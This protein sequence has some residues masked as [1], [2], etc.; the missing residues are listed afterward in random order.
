M[1]PFRSLDVSLTHHKT[2][3]LSLC[4]NLVPGFS[5]AEG[6]VQIAKTMSA[7]TGLIISPGDALMYNHRPACRPI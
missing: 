2:T 4:I 7:L 6:Y 5:D 3:G 1:M